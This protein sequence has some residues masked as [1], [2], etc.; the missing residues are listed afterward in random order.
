MHKICCK[1]D[2]LPK[3]K[4]IF[5]IVLYKSGYVGYRLSCT[6]NDRMQVLIACKNSYILAYIFLRYSDNCIIWTFC[7]HEFPLR[8]FK[9]FQTWTTFGVQHRQVSVLFKP[10]VVYIYFKFNQFIVLPVWL[11]S[12]HHFNMFQWHTFHWKRS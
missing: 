9:S 6:R 7:Y 12:N 5:E 1:R 10:R 2:H 4:D 3:N 8:S 11:M